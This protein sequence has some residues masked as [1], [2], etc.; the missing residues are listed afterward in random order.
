MACNGAVVQGGMC[1]RAETAAAA[2]A[3]ADAT[4]NVRASRRTLRHPRSARPLACMRT[5]TPNTQRSSSAS[6]RI[7]AVCTP[8][9]L[10][11]AG[12]PRPTVVAAA[13]AVAP[14]FQRFQHTRLQLS[15]L[16]QHKTP[17]AAPRT[18]CNSTA[19]RASAARSWP[20]ASGAVLATPRSA[21]SSCG[22]RGRR[23]RA[24]RGRLAATGGL[25]G[26]LTAAGRLGRC[27]HASHLLA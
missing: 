24:P 17:V 3:A 26:C 13:A 5:P 6:L 27:T 8:K 25:H 1:L 15:T 12:P 10:E 14:P 18:P 11:L 23:G 16:T 7:G 21:G 22:V 19:S 20:A 2:A 9:Q 4:L